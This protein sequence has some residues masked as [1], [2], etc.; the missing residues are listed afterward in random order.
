[1]RLQTWYAVAPRATLLLALL[2]LMSIL[3][4]AAVAGASLLPTQLPPPVGPA[5]N[6]LI[7]F[8]ST[9]D[10]WVVNPDGTGRRQLTSSSA[11][12]HSPSW[13]RDG[14]RLA[15]WSQDAAGAASSLIV[16]NADGSNP[17]TIATDEGGRTALQFLDWSPDGSHVVWSF[18]D[19]GSPAP[20]ERVYVAATDGS[21]W[22]QVGDP[23]LV[24][25]VPSWSPD[26]SVITFSGSREGVGSDCGG[27]TPCTY[28]EQGVYVMASDG[29]DVRHLSKLIADEEYS[30]YRNDWS[31]DGLWIATSAMGHL[32][33][34]AADG[35]EE[36]KVT[37]FPEDA[38]V[39]R[40]SP[41]GTR[42][43]YVNSGGLR[44]MP[45]EGGLSTRLDPSGSGHVWS[46]DGTLV[47]HGGGFVGADNVLRVID[48]VTGEVQAAIEGLDQ[49]YPEI[50]HYPSWQRL[51]P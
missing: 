14:T 3:A 4:V 1:M 51:A 11:L 34:V 13:S 16:I 24:A 50:Y 45:A 36:H 48:A 33:L 31:P 19:E 23:T 28:A 30:F 20:N 6:G 17:T 37:D 9:G 39:P 41:D 10:I 43:L 35:S 42:L 46:P 8:N 15:Y 27:S 21:G 2:V 22:S 47:T 29:T 38:L 25:R 12:E 18:G 49:S 7:A 26:G 5:A 44:A 40:W 32:W